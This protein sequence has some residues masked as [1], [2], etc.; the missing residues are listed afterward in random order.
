MITV[1]RTDGQ[2]SVMHDSQFLHETWTGFQQTMEAVYAIAT[3]QRLGTAASPHFGADSKA[4]KVAME[5]AKAKGANFVI[6]LLEKRSVAA[7]SHFKDY[8][9]RQYGIHSVCITWDKKRGFNSQYW[10][11]YRDEAKPQ[12]WWDQSYGRRD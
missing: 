6:F 2:T 4:A 1:P 7:Y 8:A 10:G 11:K 5:Q 3:F 9:D 12:G